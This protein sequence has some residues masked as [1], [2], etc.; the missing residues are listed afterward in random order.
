MIITY[1]HPWI[2]YYTDYRGIKHLVLWF[3]NVK[4]ERKF[5]NLIGSQE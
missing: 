2:D 3:T 4:G 1:T 5:I